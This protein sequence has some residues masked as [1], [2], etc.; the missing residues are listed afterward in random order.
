MAKISR[1]LLFKTTAKRFPIKSH[2]L[3]FN[4]KLWY[5]NGSVWTF[6][7]NCDSQTILLN[8]ANKTVAQTSPLEFEAIERNCDWETSFWSIPCITIQMKVLIKI[9]S[10]NQITVEVW[11]FW[12][13]T[14]R[15]ILQL[16]FEAI[17]YNCDTQI[18]HLK[19]LNKSESLN[20][21]I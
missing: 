9:V 2:F 4:E 13:Q 14:C 12:T 7:Y 11:S 6:K 1:N 20:L 19:L 10:L 8:L 3:T 16:E 5:S 17:E 18:I 15:S 21:N